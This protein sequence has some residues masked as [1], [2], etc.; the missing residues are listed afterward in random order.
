MSFHVTPILIFRVFAPKFPYQP[1]ARAFRPSPGPALTKSLNCIPLIL[2]SPESN[3]RILMSSWKE[4]ADY[5]G[6]DVRTCLRWEGT[7]GLP[8]HRLSGAPRS[9]IFAYKDELDRWLGQKNGEGRLRSKRGRGFLGALHPGV[10]VSFAVGLIILALSLTLLKKKV[11]AGPADFRIEGAALVMLDQNGR[12][13]WRFDTHKENLEDGSFYHGGFQQKRRVGETPA[14]Q[15]PLLQI[16]DINRDQKP[17]ILFSVQTRDQLGG[18]LL[19]CFDVRGRVLWDYQM[20]REIRFGPRTYTADFM[21]NG[22]CAHDCDGD[23]KQEIL[24]IGFQRPDWP[25]QVVLLDADGKSLGEYWNSGQFNDFQYADLTGDGREEIILAGTNNEYREGILAVFDPAN[26][27]GGSP[28]IQDEFRCPDLEI[29]SELAYLR[30]PRTDVDKD[31]YLIESVARLYLTNDRT[32]SAV[33]Y[34]S[35]IDFILDYSLKPRDIIF[36][37]KFKQ[38]HREAILAGKKVRALDKGYGDEL[39]KRIRYFDYENRSWGAKPSVLRNPP[40]GVPAPAAGTPGE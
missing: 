31:K 16:G 22:L 12:E 9:R 13:L 7:R 33:T 32:I 5:L 28:Q 17:E 6:C 10:V 15:L 20:G 37:N 39:I 2:M 24:V 38:M 27:S 34:G 19:I 18:G 11:P 4:I 35:D 36:S 29:G 8:V 3:S 26:I 14:I 25:T 23:G 40:R 21:I 30:F 1:R